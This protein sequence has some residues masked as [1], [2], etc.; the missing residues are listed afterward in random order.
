MLNSFATSL[1]R[2]FSPKNILPQKGRNRLF[3]GLPEAVAIADWRESRKN[4]GMGMKR[5]RFAGG[6]FRP[7]R[8][9]R[10]Q[11][12]AET[13]LLAPP[14]E[15]RLPGFGGIHFETLE[16]RL[17]LSADIAYMAEANVSVDLMLRLTTDAGA[18]I[19]Q[20]IDNNAAEGQN[21]LIRE[22]LL[23]DTTLVTITGS[24]LDDSLAF[25][26]DMGFDLGGF[27]ITFD[28]GGGSDTLRDAGGGSDTT[29]NITGDG[30]GTVSNTVD[31]D[32]PTDSQRY[33]LAFS[34]V[35]NL[36]GAI[37]NADTFELEA[38]G[39]IDSI[40]GGAMGDDVLAMGDEGFGIVT[41]VATGSDAGSVDRDGDILSYVGIEFATPATDTLMTSLEQAA[42]Q[43]DEART[44][45]ESWPLMGRDIGVIDQS[46]GEWL[47]LGTLFSVGDY[48]E[49]YLHPALHPD[50][51]PTGDASGDDSI[52]PGD[53]SS[54]HDVPTWNGLAG[55]LGQYW[56]DGALSDTGL[57]GNG[58][59]TPLSITAAGD[60]LTIA[61]AD[62]L[63][64]SDEMVIGIDEYLTPLGVTA[65]DDLKLTTNTTLDV[66]FSLTVDTSGEMPS[67]G[68]ELGKLD[69]GVTGEADEIALG[70][71]LGP[72]ALSMG[73]AVDG[74]G[75]VLLDLG[76]SISL[77]DGVPAFAFATDEEGNTRNRLEADL[78]IHARLGEH[79]LSLPSAGVP[80][81]T[82]S[83]GLLPEAGN[84]LRFATE[85]FDHL[86]DLENFDAVKVADMLPG[87]LAWF[88]DIIGDSSLLA[89]EIP[90]LGGVTVG[91]ALR[92]DT[93]FAE[94]SG[95]LTAFD[96][97]ENLTLEGLLDALQESGVISGPDAVGFDADSRALTVSLAFSTTSHLD[98][99]L[100][101][102]DLDLAGSLASLTADAA[103][104]STPPMAVAWIS[105]WISMEK[106]VR[107][108]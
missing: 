51:D 84:P 2:R 52:P 12:S 16:P 55:Y 17:L 76:G 92:F 59:D 1:A 73:D 25:D 54:T 74:Y 29:W 50:A 72:L 78:P 75:R 97:P 99:H 77:A 41:H 56:I 28:G 26:L 91:D 7:W 57:A 32:D 64:R 46:L 69:V 88:T 27:L 14:R 4:F 35:E 79:L 11:D 82:L 43:V 42:D 21:P 33:S 53:Y 45:M 47:D 67:V 31:A 85:N 60:M 13:L 38:A 44:R 70:A 34:S 101:F 71:A 19:L 105:S 104:G 107:R 83:G 63:S 81:V 9:N 36:I 108:A 10:K 40:D 58:E 62:M 103:P 66:A 68:F 86:L 24:D 3:E 6:K 5:R 23:A 106:P 95:L 8:G 100:D 18:P 98:T 30:A 87:V 94:Q 96:D 61:Y 90:F 49:R 80:R 65:P 48:V 93:A 15:H 20:L 39:S 89:Q 102:S 22:Q 37:N